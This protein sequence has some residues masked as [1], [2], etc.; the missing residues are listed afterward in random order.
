M[1]SST[2]LTTLSRA[3]L[4]VLC[5][6]ALALG[7]STN[8]AKPSE[9]PG[10][11]AVEVVAKAEPGDPA[12]PAISTGECNEQQSVIAKRADERATPWTILQHLEKNFS[13]MRVSW[14]MKETLY[15]KYVVDTGA[16][17]FGRCND[18]GCYLFAAPTS[19]SATRYLP[20]LGL[21]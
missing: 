12:E 7:C 19:V 4:T 11:P 5:A 20:T 13:D 17:N 18:T 3:A 9:P 15:Q 2:L 14:L 10:E 6:G 8:R 16:T 1:P 21:T